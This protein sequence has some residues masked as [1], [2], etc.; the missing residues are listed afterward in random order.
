MRKRRVSLVSLVAL[1]LL[2]AYGCGEEE[3][4]GEPTGAECPPA[5]TL[6][7]ANFGQ[8]FFEEY[9]LGCH[10]ESVTGTDRNGAPDDHNFDTVAEI[11]TFHEHIDE[12]AGSGPDATNE[13]MPEGDGEIPTLAERQQLAEWLACGSPD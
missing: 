5:S 9:C 6:T 7:Y 4:H 12:M 13:F 2:M 11:R 3:E 8:A 1:P 10:S